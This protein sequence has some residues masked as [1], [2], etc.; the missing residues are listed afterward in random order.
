MR[1]MRLRRLRTRRPESF[2]VIVVI[3]AAAFLATGCATAS[4]APPQASSTATPTPT[5]PAAGS[6][7]VPFTI[8]V[9]GTD[10]FTPYIAVIPTGTPIHWLNADTVLHTVISGPTSDGGAINPAPF[11][12]VLQPGDEQTLT[13]RQSGLYYYY[14]GAHAT[15]GADGR[16]ASMSNTRAYPLAMDGF[17]YAVGTGLSGSPSATINMTT[18]D[19]FAPW[20]TVLTRG[21][22]ITWTNQTAQ[23]MSIT[24][25]Q[26]RDALNPVPLAV[27]VQPG[28][29]TTLTL[30]TPGVYNYYS[31]Q[32]AT[33][34]TQWNRPI[35]RKGAQTYP[36]PMEGI[37]VVL[38]S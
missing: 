11:Q 2:V 19:T 29:K 9:P 18:N 10:L 8:T 24:T 28:G 7:A 21:G 13:L 37:I 20:M 31:P 15:A 34:D 16:A 1:L 12:L 23:V 14:C 3:V 27:Q 6:G 38:A 5:S 33:L 35:A 22:S 4:G 17:I 25:T 32:A 30:N 36:A 26:K